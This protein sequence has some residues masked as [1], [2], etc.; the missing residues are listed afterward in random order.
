[1]PQR[2][3]FQK[4]HGIIAG[5]VVAVV[6]TVILIFARAATLTASFEA[7]N[8]MISRA[9][10]TA[11]ATVSGGKAVTFSA[12]PCLVDQK[13][14]NP[15]RPWLG[16]FANSYPGVTGWRNDILDHESRIGR[17]LDIVHNYHAP[18]T[19]PPLSADEKY[20]INRGHTILLV[21]WKPA[22]PWS[23][24]DGSNATVNAQID[25]AADSIKSVAPKKIMLTIYHEPEPD[26]TGGAS[27]CT[28]STYKTDAKGGTPAEYRA[29]WQNVRSRFDAKGATNVIWVMNY[30]GFSRWDCLIDDMW[31]GN[32]L[33]DWVMYDPYAANNT[34]TWDSTVGRFYNVLT[35]KTT[36]VTNYT[37]KPWGLAEFGIGPNADQQHTYDYYADAKTALE[38]NKYSRL[39]AY[40]AFDHDGVHSTMVGYTPA[41]ALVADP[42]EQQRYNAFANSTAIKGVASGL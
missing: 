31:P 25:Q 7:E 37:S 22:L 6:G 42:A 11:S 35:S 40:V 13:L 1:M 18:G 16:A 39:K 34:E 4:A 36:S 19:A 21:N 38:T 33:V 41:P 15:C 27:G 3:P 9:T 8:G 30:M 12:A 23:D 29:M 32:Y 14:V 26:V 2:Q 28:T 5:I 24:G 20:F 10:T 17:Q